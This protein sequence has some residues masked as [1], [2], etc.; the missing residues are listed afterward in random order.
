[1]IDKRP[2]QFPNPL[3]REWKLNHTSLIY[4]ALGVHTVSSRKEALEFLEPLLR[5]NRI[6]HRC[7][8]PD[9]EYRQNPE[10]EEAEIWKR[11]VIFQI[12]PNSQK[13]LLFLDKNIAHTNAEERNVVELFRQHVDDLV[14]RHLGDNEG[15]ASR[16]PQ[17]M[18]TLFFPK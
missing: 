2:E 14:E 10:A 3:L 9:N 7:Y 1:M 13:L 11:K 18:N 17:G 8:G 12:I 4:A 6:I 5:A 15:I 16:F